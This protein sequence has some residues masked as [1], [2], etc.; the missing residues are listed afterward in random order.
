MNDTRMG[1][2]I[3][4][5]AAQAG[6]AV[7]NRVE[8]VQLL[9]DNLGKTKGARVRDNMTGEEWDMEATVVINAPGP[10]SGYSS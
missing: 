2:S 9:K 1:I 7:A 3:A 5:T 10:F 8:V 6:A 4:L